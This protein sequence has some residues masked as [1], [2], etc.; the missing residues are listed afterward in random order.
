[1]HRGETT[2]RHGEKTVIFQLRRE[3]SE[4]SYTL[5]SNCQPTEL[6]ENQLLLFKNIPHPTQSIVFVMAATAN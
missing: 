5:I 4:K 3:A 2:R 6:W 1:M